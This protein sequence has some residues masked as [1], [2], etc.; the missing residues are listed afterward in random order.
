MYL[1]W[2][3]ISCFLLLVF[4]FHRCSASICS[5]YHSS[6]TSSQ[7][8]ECEDVTSNSQPAI[9]LKCITHVK[10]PYFPGNFQYKNIEIES[11]A[12]DFDFETNPFNSLSLNTLRIRH[13]NLKNVN[14]QT[15]ANLKHFDKF[16]LENSTIK[17]LSTSSGNFQDVF[18][19]N[20]FQ[21]LKSLT[22]KN[23]HYH[24]THKHDKKLNLELLLQQ[25]PHL[26][27]LEL[28]NIYLDNYRYYDIKTLGQNLTY[29]SLA[30]THQTS[31]VPIQYLSSLQSLL[32][33]HLP[34]VFHSQ[35]LISSLGKLKHLKY[36]LFDYNQLK[37]IDHLQSE[38]IDDIDLSSNLIE[39]I[40]EYTFEHVPKLRQLILSG[41]P[42]NSIDKN[43]FCGID[44]LQRLSIY[45]KHSSI[46]PLNNCLLIHYPHLQISQDS[47]TRF[48]CDCLLQT[49]FN[50]KRQQTNQSVNRIFKLNQGCLLRNESSPAIQLYELDKH[51]NCSATNSCERLCQDRKIKVLKTEVSPSYNGQVNPKDASLSTSLYSFFSYQYFLLLLC[52]LYL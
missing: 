51:F 4:D 36:I 35:P 47:Q 32:L 11:C 13:C 12:D 10:M 28:M 30:N 41:N 20:S 8:C 52:F 1:S 3:S 19:A 45:I 24:Q 29:L 7:Q 40:D 16:V 39:L 6:Q 46:S 18:S 38:T 14:E 27:R 34:D 43:A 23:V 15:F 22:L 49:V 5:E 31:L 17:S 9:S 21:I 48:Q 33:R 37:S 2:I 44:H 25:L 42:L 26:Y 50:T